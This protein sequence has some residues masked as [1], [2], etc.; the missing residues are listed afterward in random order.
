MCSCEL[1]MTNEGGVVE[2]VVNDFH[3]SGDIE[4]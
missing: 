2:V 3:D 1:E 4:F